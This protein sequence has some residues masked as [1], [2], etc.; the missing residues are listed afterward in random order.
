[1]LSRTSKAS[2]LLLTAAVLAVTACSGDGTGGGE[3]AEDDSAFPT[4]ACGAVVDVSGSADGGRVVERASEWIAEFL[5][6]ASSSG[7]RCDRL[8]ITV[9]I[10]NSEALTCDPVEL[11]I[12]V[13][14]ANSR[15]QNASWER[16]R[17]E[18]GFVPVEEGETPSGPGVDAWEELRACGVRMIEER[19]NQDNKLHSD[20]LGALRKL[21]DLMDDGLDGGRIAVVSDGEHNAETH[22]GEL[23]LGS[24]ESRA[25]EIERLREEG[26]LPDLSGAEVVFYGLGSGLE[27][28]WTSSEVTRLKDF[29]EEV[30]LAAGA[31]AVDDASAA[32]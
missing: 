12:A 22:F 16:N 11:E 1:M 23:D 26:L 10:H 15:A 27:A 21:G 17:Q 14:G 5:D 19:S 24:A 3:S 30:S 25:E 6:P 8:V 20:V 28:S 9:A 18:T 13:S 31:T 2:A 29:W 32:E 7:S 4:R